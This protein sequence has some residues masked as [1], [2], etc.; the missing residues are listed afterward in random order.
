MHVY[1]DM[2]FFLIFKINI[3]LGHSLILCLYSDVCGLTHKSK[4]IECINKIRGVTFFLTPL[5]EIDG[6]TLSSQR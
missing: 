4:K 5:D 3:F 2:A 6:S 1:W